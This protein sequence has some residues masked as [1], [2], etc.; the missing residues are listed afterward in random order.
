MADASHLAKLR[1]GIDA[2]NRWREEH[3]DVKPDLR[4]ANLSQTDLSNA[5]LSHVNLHHADLFS[6]NLFRADLV[7]AY[8]SGANLS[9]A[10]LS[11]AN[12]SRADLSYATLSGAYLSG[13]DLSYAILTGAYLSRTNLS[14]ATLSGANLSNADLTG[15]DLRHTDLM[16]AILVDTTIKDAIFT[17]CLVYG[18]SV[19]NLK[20]RP[21]E[22][23]NLIISRYH[24]P[25]ITVDDLHVAQF[26]YLLIN[27]PELN[28]VIDTITSKVVLILGRFTDERKPVLN[29]I[30]DKLRE[31]D[32][33]PVMFD[34]TKPASQDYLQPISTLAHLAH[35]VIADFT[36]PKIVLEE[37][38]HIMREATV[39]LIPIL[40]NGEEEPVTLYNLRADERPVLD[41]YWYA[42]VDDLLAHLQERIIGPAEVKADALLEK[43]VQ[44]LQ[45]RHQKS[46]K[47]RA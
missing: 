30:R 23:K 4:D 27:Y 35:F 37:V 18:I 40:L 28:K 20:G 41:T 12:L 44:L 17:G 2:W 38:S 22:Q 19:W 9:H 6:A 13:A 16:R 42:D 10:N 3:P 43:K 14:Y 21:N 34:F 46:V 5:D 24:E 39:P 47:N 45:E 25:A 33:V 8:L 31:Y 29:A 1:E 36:D 15:A 32:Y 26:I 11:H 7:I